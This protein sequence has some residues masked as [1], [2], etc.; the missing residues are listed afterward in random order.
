M[1][2]VLQDSLYTGIRF[3]LNLVKRGLK[4]KFGVDP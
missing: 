3:K 4:S 1:I 2:G